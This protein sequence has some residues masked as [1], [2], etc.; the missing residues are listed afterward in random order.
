MS[1]FDFKKVLR[2]SIEHRKGIKSEAEIGAAAGSAASSARGF[3]DRLFKGDG[4]TPE[5]STA[6]PD[7]ESEKDLGNI[8]KAKKTLEAK[9][10]DI[11]EKNPDDPNETNQMLD[12]KREANRANAKKALDALTK[13]YNLKDKLP[14]KDHKY[15]SDMITKIDGEVARN[16]KAT[17]KKYSSEEDTPVSADAEEAPV[18]AD[19]EEK[20]TPG[21]SPK[22]LTNL[23]LDP[24]DPE[25]RSKGFKP[26][27]YEPGSPESLINIALNNLSDPGLRS[28][29]LKF[30]Q[31]PNSANR[32][33]FM[34]NLNNLKQGLDSANVKIEAIDRS[35]GSMRVINRSSIDSGPIEEIL[36][37]FYPF[38]KERFGFDKDPIL[39]L[40]SDKENAN[41]ALGKTAYYNP[42]DMS[43][44]IY[45]DKRHPK[46]IM[47]S[48]SHELVHHAQNC[49]G[50]L[51]ISQ[52][53]GE[54]YAQTNPH[55]RKME[56]DANLRGNMC[57]R[58]YE[59][60]KKHGTTYRG[61]LTERRERL[62]KKLLDGI[63]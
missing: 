4:K 12:Q 25:N 2:E 52:H 48:V 31:N 50:D 55:L 5:T 10:N 34:S 54:G 29:Y 35:M 8:D 16:L 39:E 37:D 60:R 40:I 30:K 49:S 11:I 56:E 6:P 9:L 27:E 41:D 38:A 57:L 42:A 24:V 44:T 46:D 15:L 7:T 14:S 13:A 17:N 59:D 23:L 45:V 62:F 51:D 36:K 63:K 33:S 20:E 61:S 47:R 21:A 43:I 58:D 28:N 32:K 26:K 3:M 22:P 1:E 53:A 18:S 19:V